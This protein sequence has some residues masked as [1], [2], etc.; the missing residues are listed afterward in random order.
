[1]MCVPFQL[2]FIIYTMD[3]IQTRIPRK[4]LR[5]AYRVSRAILFHKA[6]A[7]HAIRIL[8]KQHQPMALLLQ[9]CALL[10]V[11]TALR[12]LM[13]YKRGMVSAA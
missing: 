5:C 3:Q 6:E 7:T 12:S 13:M 1:M 10:I 2:D 9:L 8:R 11:M 4:G